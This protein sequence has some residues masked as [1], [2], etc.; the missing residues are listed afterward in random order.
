[1]SQATEVER[2]FLVAE[3]PDLTRA[4]AVRIRQGYLTSKADSVEI[5]LRQK[6]DTYL[7]TLKKGAGLE[8][9]E[10][11]ANIS[12]VHFDAFWPA[13]EGRRVE[14]TRWSGQLAGGATF[15]L[16]IF[17]GTLAPLVLV[18]VEFG[19]VK[20]A[21]GFQPPAWFGQDVTD[22]ARYSNASLAASG[23]PAPSA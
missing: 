22:D 18:E 2:K 14:K 15:E 6:G 4:R 8:R 5:R 23:A 11:E 12:E 3:L 20:E 21:T 1:M 10:C 7:T 16:D 9:V 17:E 19:T 13:T